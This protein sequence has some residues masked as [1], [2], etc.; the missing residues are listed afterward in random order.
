[1]PYGTHLDDEEIVNKCRRSSKF[2]RTGVN[3]LT[4]YQGQP[5]KHS[6]DVCDL[7]EDCSVLSGHIVYV[8]E[9]HLRAG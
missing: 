6:P 3:T 8:C 2:R 1:M 9:A 7:T 5:I 4:M